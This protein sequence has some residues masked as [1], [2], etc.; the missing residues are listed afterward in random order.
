MTGPATFGIL[1]VIATFRIIFAKNM[2][3][4]DTPTFI[5]CTRYTRV[6][7]PRGD[8]IG[9]NVHACREKTSSFQDTWLSRESTRDFISNLCLQLSSSRV[10]IKLKQTTTATAVR[11]AP[12]FPIFLH[13]P[14][15][16]PFLRVFY[17]APLIRLSFVLSF[18]LLIVCIPF[19]SIRFS[20]S[21]STEMLYVR[22]FRARSRLR[23]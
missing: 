14:S 22:L 16:F 15:P 2:D 8:S 9:I 11:C 10:G 18:S 20:L 3:I 6:R 13:R 23:L 7:L 1:A 19:V 17:L 12:S 21:P 4:R 5:V